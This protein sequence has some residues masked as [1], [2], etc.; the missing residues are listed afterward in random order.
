MSSTP[1]DGCFRIALVSPPWP[2]FNR[3][4]IQLG[5]LKAY[6]DSR[7]SRRSIQVDAHHFYLD[8]AKQVGY[9]PYH[10][11]SQRMWSAEAVFAALLY[12]ERRAAAARLFQKET[13]G[14]YG[15]LGKNFDRIVESSRK[16]AAEYVQATDWKRYGLVG[17]SMCLCQTTSTL[18]VIRQIKQRCPKLPVVVG[19]GLFE[20]DS[21]QAFFRIFPEIDAIVVGEGERPLEK[22]VF[23]LMEGKSIGELRQ[24]NGVITRTGAES[25]E[26]AAFWQ[27]PDLD[28]LPIPD[29]D[30]Y[31]RLLKSF[32]PEKSFFPTLPVEISRGCWWQS[33]KA[34]RGKRGCAFCNLNLQWS[35]YRSKSPKRAAAEIDALTSRYQTLSVA[36]TDNVLPRRESQEIFDGIK[37][38]KKDLSIFAE[39]RPTI[40]PDLL[41]KLR[42]AGVGEVQ[43]GIEALSS[44]LLKKLNKGTSAI[45]NLETMKHCEA[46]GIKQTSNLILCF[47]GSDQEDVRQTLRALEFAAPFRPLKVAH[48][49]LG[50]GSSVYRNPVQFGLTAVY[51]HPR[52]RALFPAE[53]TGSVRLLVQTYRGDRTLQQRLW[54]PV[55]Q[56]VRQWKADYADLKC[57]GEGPILGFRDGR[58]FLII[59]QRRIGGDPIRHRLTGTSRKIYLQCSRHRSFKTILQRFPEFSE[60]KIRS[61]LHMMVE[62]RLIFEENDRYLS[63]AVPENPKWVDPKATVKQ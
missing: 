22:I 51:N 24:T 28:R 17:F 3:P 25:G 9:R 54:R 11:I 6:I 45:Q 1:Q 23:H 52:Y 13:A 8:V 46:L 34:E 48:F 50:I 19:G 62:K 42:A 53:V 44:R 47:P 58:D 49:W 33:S 18:Y 21:M 41:R 27:V 29:F 61:F 35:G 30:D 2:L 36:L 7:F 31:F 63:L 20:P 26:Q 55:K 5:S 4:S 60:G 56:R 38:L 14:K 43:I 59:R 57:S 40:S 15:A 12:P 32:G 16:A 10:D 39:I 37:S